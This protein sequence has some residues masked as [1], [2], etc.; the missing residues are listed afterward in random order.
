ME[1]HGNDIGVKTSLGKDEIINIIKK[2]WPQLV[3]EYDDDSVFVYK[4][5]SAQRNWDAKG[6]TEQ[7]DTEMIHVM[8]GSEDGIVWFVIDDNKVND[9]I[10][11][12]IERK[13]LPN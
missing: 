12:E 1:I 3:V 7:N 10:I 5:K 6:W 13:S 9:R 8:F 2:F 11:K 4:N